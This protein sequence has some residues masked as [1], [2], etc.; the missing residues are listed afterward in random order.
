MCHVYRLQTTVQDSEPSFIIQ[1]TDLLF[2]TH[3]HWYNSYLDFLCVN[4]SSGIFFA[5]RFLVFLV[6]ALMIVH[7]LL[8]LVVVIVILMIGVSSHLLALIAVL[9]TLTWRRRKAV[10]WVTRRRKLVLV[11]RS[12]RRHLRRRQVMRPSMRH[13]SLAWSS[14]FILWLSLS[15]I[16][17]RKIVVPLIVVHHRGMVV[18][19]VPRRRHSVRRNSLGRTHV[20]GKIDVDVCA[21]NIGIIG[22]RRLAFS[23]RRNLSRLGLVLVLVLRRRRMGLDSGFRVLLSVRRHRVVHV[24]RRIVVP[25]IGRSWIVVRRL[26][27]IFAFL[28]FTVLRAVVAFFWMHW[29]LRVVHRWVAIRRIVVLVSFVSFRMAFISVVGV[30][31]WSFVSL[32]LS[33]SFPFGFS[34]VAFGRLMVHV[35]RMHWHVVGVVVGLHVSV[36]VCLAF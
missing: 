15:S 9:R 21:A 31:S 11:R 2:F 22:V 36:L 7:I 16:L 3:F 32:S 6:V 24:V 1:S 5:G 17:I 4:K 33:L 35:G 29:V 19:G 25:G 20:H 34:F 12:L 14:M 8:L 18:H 26:I 10:V 28:L 27:K 23:L 13:I 30:F